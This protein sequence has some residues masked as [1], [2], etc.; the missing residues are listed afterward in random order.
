[1][2][3][4]DRIQSAVRIWHSTLD[5]VIGGG[6]LVDQ[7]H[8]MTCAHVVGEATGKRFD[9]EQQET[10]P[11]ELSIRFDFVSAQKEHGGQMYTARPADKGWHAEKGKLYPRDVAVLRVDTGPALP[12]DAIAV[13]ATIEID[14]GD[15]F[16]AY[17]IKEGIPDGTYIQGTFVGPIPPD[18]VEVIS[19]HV[20]QAIRPGCSGAG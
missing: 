11:T 12:K 16:Q 4:G 20:D 1:M 7:Q 5:Q 2:K 14:W 17:G 6:F 3:F 18:R 9:L 13:V 8:I 10:A 15:R 19:E